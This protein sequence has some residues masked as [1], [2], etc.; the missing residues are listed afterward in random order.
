MSFITLGTFDGVHPGHKYIIE[1]LK[2]EAERKNLESLLLYFDLPPKL[3]LTK[4]LKGNVLTPPNEKHKLLLSGGADKT[5]KIHFDRKFANTPCRKFFDEI[6]VKKYKMKGLIVGRD[7]AFG[8]HRQGHLDF[9]RQQCRR[10]HIPLIIVSFICAYGH[11][12]SSSVIRQVL[13]AG[14]IEK[15]NNLLGRHFTLTGKV[16]KDAGLGKK[17]GFPTA[18]LKIHPHK[19]IPPGV[20]AVKVH[21]KNHIYNGV[22]NAGYRPTVKLKKPQTPTVEVHILDFDKNIYRRELTV[23][24]LWKIRREK[25]FKNLSALK[26]QI[27]KDTLTAKK[28]LR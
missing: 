23:E 28:I 9:L 26:F 6:L 19:I 20:F 15:A 27:E 22:L 2:I 12:I 1:Q 14:D 7:F 3:L 16:K 8:C 13:S 17:L 21:L 24:F 18:N 5:I 11:K 25:K 4:N 10:R